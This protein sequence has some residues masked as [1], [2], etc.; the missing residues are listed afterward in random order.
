M[1]ITCTNLSLGFGHRVVSEDISFMV[2]KGDYLMIVGENG[3]G[4][5]TLMRA[6][7]GLHPIIKGEIVFS[8]DL[9]P[10]ELG[11]LPQQSPYQRNFPASVYEVVI[12]GCLNRC[13]IRP[14]YNREEKAIAENNMER[15]GILNLKNQSYQELSGGQQQRVLLARAL[16]ATGK[17]L[18]LDEPVSGLDPNAAMDLYALI[19]ELNQ[20]LGITIL[21]ISHDITSAVSQ[22]SHILHLAQR[23]LFFGTSEEYVSSDTGKLYLKASG[24]KAQ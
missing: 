17:V 8:P 15:L 3:T 4:K 22:A 20:E 7:L 11:Y 24:G 12:S 21:V 13:G 18:L 6:L 1:Q 23:P 5:T 16:C 9:K 10:S 2:S 14:F 19:K